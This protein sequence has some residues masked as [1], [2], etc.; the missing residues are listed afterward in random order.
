MTK[1]KRV[2]I[3]DK[4]IRVRMANPNTFEAGSFRLV[5]IDEEKGIFA[6]I[7][8]TKEDYQTQAYVFDVD[9]W[10]EDTAKD[11]VNN[12][13]KGTKSYN[14][15]I[16][17]HRCMVTANL[18]LCKTKPNLKIQE[19]EE[20]P[21]LAVA[22]VNSAKAELK[23]KYYFYVEA[24]HSGPNLNGD[25]FFNEE[26]VKSYKTMSMQLID[27]EHMKD[28]IIGF[29]MESELINN[30]TSEDED[31]LAVGV[32]GV[33]N[34]LS[35]YM[36]INETESL[37]R[38]DIIKQ[39]FFE[40]KLAVSM[41]AFFD[42]IKCTNCGFETDDFFEFEHHRFTAHGDSPDVYRGLIGVDFTGLGIV[43]MPADP[44]AQA[45]GLRTSDD[46]TLE[47]IVASNQK[48]LA[49]AE[50][51]FGNYS[52]NVFLGCKLADLEPNIDYLDNKLKIIA[53]KQK[54][55]TKKQKN[56]DKSNSTTGTNLEGGDIMFKLS[57][58]VKGAKTLSDVF[59]IAQNVLKDYIG[60]KVIDKEASDAFKA[61]L[62]EVVSSFI[63]KDGFEIST[64]YTVSGE[65]K[66]N[67]ITEA[68]NEEKNLAKEKEDELNTVIGN[69]ENEKKELQAQIDTT[70]K[71]LDDLRLA[72][73]KKLVEDKLV[74][75]VSGIEKSGLPLS[76]VMKAHVN[77]IARPII[78]AGENVDEELKKITNE[79]VSMAKQAKLTEAS[80]STS[81]G[82]GDPDDVD[83][84][85][86][87]QK[88][89]EKHTEEK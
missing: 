58:H 82:I 78:E 6:V 3:S 31:D 67:A 8:K 7:G 1:I 30:A 11:W 87:L 68:R 69:L 56:N 76:D 70:K 85:T 77:T 20:I 37:T 88:I 86:T 9:K 27:W 49:Y 34:R 4:Y 19:G 71:E 52:I 50:E 59:V 16:A 84:Q 12:H 25:F 22:D 43:E 75:L 29:T 65:D 53:K 54:N 18:V 80:L 17:S 35:P 83:I 47:E 48:A 51:K 63:S 55:S 15:L 38:D 24:V 14:E 41:E 44:E 23:D 32:N 2:D 66:L 39:R 45:K 57:E 46:G 79:F 28:Q 42:R 33:L 62:A 36:L 13:I 72:E 21:K 81:P 40:E 73:A 26:L 74:L 10:T 61:E 89:R 5:P 64:I 60:Y